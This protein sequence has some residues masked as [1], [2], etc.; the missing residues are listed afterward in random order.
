MQL[1]R[2]GAILAIAASTATAQPAHE[3]LPYLELLGKGGLWGA[4]YEYRIGR[5]SAG[6]VLSYYRLDGD[7]F[8]NVSPYV[9]FDPV[10]GDRAK[11]FVHV[12]P[13]LLRRTT[14][15]PGPEWSGMSST[16][17]A[18]EASSGIDVR[19]GNVHL[20]SYVMAAYGSHFAPGLGFAAGWVP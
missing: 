1:L 6:G 7:R 12:G 18:L 10:L 13:Q 3:H 9:G 11:W 17:F 8:T 20:R 16:G 15:S 2:V 14:P 5:W 19:I 4:G